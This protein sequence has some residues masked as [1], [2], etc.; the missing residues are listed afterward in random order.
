MA[1]KIYIYCKAYHLFHGGYI[2]TTYITTRITPINNFLV[3][4]DNKECQL[5][6][7]PGVTS[8]FPIM[9]HY[10]AMLVIM[11]SAFLMYLYGAWLHIKE[12]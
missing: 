7:K 4:H 3:S 2:T 9:Y 11:I 10:K 1:N 6:F 12:R 8:H 5:F